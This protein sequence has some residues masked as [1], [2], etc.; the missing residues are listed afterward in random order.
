ML[1][2][3]E[4]CPDQNL[5][6]M[7]HSAVCPFMAIHGE[8]ECTCFHLNLMDYSLAC[9]LN[10]LLCADDQTQQLCE[11]EFHC[12]CIPGIFGSQF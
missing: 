6:T 8:V 9:Q 1:P 7:D 12:T 11:G 2:C 4:E 3:E 10:T 5:Y